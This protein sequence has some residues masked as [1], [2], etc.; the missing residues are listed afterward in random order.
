GWNIGPAY[1]DSAA[2]GMGLTA[3]PGHDGRYD[4][5]DEYMSV[6][7]QLWEA[8]WEHG[9]VRRDKK[10]RTFADPA[11]VHRVR[12]HGQHYQVDAIHLAEPSR[13]LTPGLYQARSST[14][15]RCFAATRA[16]CV[17]V[18]GAAKRI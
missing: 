13:Q 4:A 5:A 17:F 6:V 10:N 7:Y 9:A 2:G 18:F 15:G 3:Q 11:K 1:V 8:S 14:R 12:H 16:D